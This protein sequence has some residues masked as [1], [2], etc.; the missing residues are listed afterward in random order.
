MTTSNVLER[1]FQT[2]VSAIGIGILAWM[3][4]SLDALQDSSVA[5]KI[6]LNY[7]KEEVRNLGSLPAT[8]YTK[9]QANMDWSS[10]REDIKEIRGRLRILEV[11]R[12]RQ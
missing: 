12:T 1:H 5:T 4:A 6:E 11:S 8:I 9:D 2:I 3:G 7:I 10:N